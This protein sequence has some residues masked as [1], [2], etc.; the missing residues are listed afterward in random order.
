MGDEGDALGEAQ[1]LIL[2]EQL[3][4]RVRTDLEGSDT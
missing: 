3:D 4:R 2:Q 1:R